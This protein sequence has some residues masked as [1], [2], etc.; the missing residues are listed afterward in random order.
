MKFSFKDV[1]HQGDA[2]NY[3]DMNSVEGMRYSEWHHFNFNDDSNALYGIVNL[4]LSGNIKNPDKGRAGISLVVNERGK[5]WRGT[6]DLQPVEKVSFETGSL[7]L[8][9]AKHFVK[10]INDEYHVAAALK[11]ESINLKATWIPETAGI[12]VTNIGG[13]I[14][15]FIIP[16]LRVEGSIWIDQHEY[17]FNNATGYH[18]HNWGYWDW[19]KDIGWDWGYIIQPSSSTNNNQKQITIVYGQVTDTMRKS[20]KS[21]LVLMVWE[22]RECRQVFLDEA[23][24]ISTKGQLTGI[25]IRRV[26]GLMAMLYPG[27]SQKIPQHICVQAKDGHDYLDIE[28]SVENAIEFI[29]PHP[30][31]TGK[32]VINE[33]VGEYAVQ[34]SLN[35]QDYNF[36]YVGFAEI[37]G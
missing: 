2:I 28:M 1:I 15:T 4:S 31:N 33:L 27:R 16:R 25:E 20:A 9:I 34:G 19:G 29:I 21:D 36:S 23:V 32:T 3:R 24:T 13:I 5:I 37:T 17:K 35:G 18:D 6:M 26:P 30:N 14:N 22:G 10:L 11:D 7:N 8:N 12:R